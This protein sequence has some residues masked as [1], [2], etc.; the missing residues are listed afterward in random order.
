MSVFLPFVQG[1]KKI[2][3]SVKYS[4]FEPFN[5]CVCGEGKK[6]VTRTDKDPIESGYCVHPVT[7]Q[8]SLTKQSIKSCLFT[9]GLS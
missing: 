7:C 9:Y 5:N 3:N 6:L 8:E 4:D 1:N 2:C